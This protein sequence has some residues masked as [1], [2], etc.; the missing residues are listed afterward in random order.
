MKQGTEGGGALLVEPQ[1]FV[2]TRETDWPHV[3]D[4]ADETGAR[5]RIVRQAVLPPSLRQQQ[6]AEM[7]AGRVARE[8]DARRIAAQ[9]L[10]VAINPYDRIAH[11]PGHLV[12]RDDGRQRIFD[13]DEDRAGPRERERG[14]GPFALVRP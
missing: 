11:L 1:R 12:E 4:A 10:G 3:E 8:V 6:G 2:V 9:R 13:R 14:K 5:N 7:A